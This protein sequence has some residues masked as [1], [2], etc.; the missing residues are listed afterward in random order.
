MGCAICNLCPF[1]SCHEMTSGVLVECSP[2]KNIQLEGLIT[3]LAGVSLWYPS[4]CA[5]NSTYHLKA[6]TLS[7]RL[8]QSESC[9]HLSIRKLH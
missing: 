1:Y 3:D 7:S 6:A 2:C 8:Q 5:A 4:S 9:S